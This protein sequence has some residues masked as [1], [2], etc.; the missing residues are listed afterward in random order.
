[1]SSGVALMILTSLSVV[2]FLFNDMVLFEIILVNI[3][4]LIGFLLLN[5]PKGKIFL[6]DGGA[7]F[8]GFSLATISLLLIYSH[9]DISVFYPL[10]L[11][12]YPVWEVLFS[13]YRRKIVKKVKSTSADKMHLHQL[14]YRRI[15]KDNPQTSI[16]IFKRI[17]PFIVAATYFYDNDSILLVLI[18]LFV[19][20]YNTLYRKIVHGVRDNNLG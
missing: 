1:M 13:I 20:V 19:V 7:Y 16:Y 4:A 2:S 6:G 3:V 11:L 12:I 5:F 10:C 17:A 18:L 8:I 9:Q 14:I 15:T